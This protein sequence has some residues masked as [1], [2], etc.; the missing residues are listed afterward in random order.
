MMDENGYPTEETLEKITLWSHK[1]GFENLLHFISKLWR[2]PPYIRQEGKKWYI[3][4]GGWS[5]NEDI[6][7]ALQDNRLFWSLCWYQ[8]KRGGHH[9]FEVKNENSG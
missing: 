6:I 8:S 3:S 2:Y 7:R 5:G 1:D 4:T 9:I